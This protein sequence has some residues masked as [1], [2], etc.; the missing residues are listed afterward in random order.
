[1]HIGKSV[2]K[3]RS[4]SRDLG[5]VL[6]IFQIAEKVRRENSALRMMLRK[7]GLS[8][9]KIRRG[10]RVYR[11]FKADENPPEALLRQ[12][13]EEFLRRLAD[14]DLQRELDGLPA[15]KPQRVKLRP[16]K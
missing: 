7:Q 5:T 13:C 10:V 1:M 3:R 8:E 14:I 2:T 6:T 15:S 4:S 16:A 9:A 11:E 12:C